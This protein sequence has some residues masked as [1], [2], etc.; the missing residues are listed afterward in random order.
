M[1][2]VDAIMAI[3]GL[4]FALLIVSTLGQSSVNAV[5]AVAISSTPGMV[6]ISRSVALGTKQLDYVMAARARGESN[7][8]IVCGERLPNI[9][10]PIIVKA[11][12]RVAFAIMMF[13]TLSFLCLGAHPPSSEWV[14][15]GSAGTAYFCPAH[16]RL[17]RPPLP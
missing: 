3:P 17:S 2:T 13:A 15:M 11:T 5:L 6:R 8:Y 9:D 7:T 1:R 12:I 10:S 16:W 4:L 14:L